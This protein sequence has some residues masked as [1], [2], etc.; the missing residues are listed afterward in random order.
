M[1][2]YTIIAVSTNQRL[3]AGTQIVETLE[4]VAITSPHEVNFSVTVD[5]KPGWQD[6]LKAA[7]QAEADALESVFD[8]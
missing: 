2:G 8:F 7:A 5:K 4:A 6:A 3:V 1:A